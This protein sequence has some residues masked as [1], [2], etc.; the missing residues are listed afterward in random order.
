[1][2]PYRFGWEPLFLVLAAAAAAFYVRAIRNA[3]PVDRPGNGRAAV[4]ALGR[5]PSAE[6]ICAGFL[7][8]TGRV[9]AAL[10]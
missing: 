8:L 6:L 5:E 7:T 1:M 2:S 9:R 10:P 4:F 3:D